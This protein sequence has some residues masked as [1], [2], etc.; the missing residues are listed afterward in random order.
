M[1]ARTATEEAQT[2]TIEEELQTTE[3]QVHTMVALAHRLHKRMGQ[4]IES[5]QGSAGDGHELWRPI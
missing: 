1:G 4:E 3:E 2:M 5:G